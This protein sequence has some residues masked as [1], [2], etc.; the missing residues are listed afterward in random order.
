[1][2]IKFGN[3]FVVLILADVLWMAIAGA[4]KFY[5]L[6]AELI[7]LI[8]IWIVLTSRNFNKDSYRIGRL[9]W[10]TI[11]KDKNPFGFYFLLCFNLFL[12]LSIASILVVGVT[13]NPPVWSKT[14]YLFDRS[15]NFDSVQNFNPSNPGSQ[16]FTR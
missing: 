5:I 3:I 4:M 10:A 12:A 8:I 2:K 16:T 13:L 11:Y 1:M 14:V 15:R 7:L 9:G 6:Y